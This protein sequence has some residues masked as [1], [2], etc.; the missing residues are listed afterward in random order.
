MGDCLSEL[1]IVDQLEIY[2]VVLR[3][4][5]RLYIISLPEMAMLAFIDEWLAFARALDRVV[6]A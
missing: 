4:K 2:Q 5:K 1:N 6:A 3:K